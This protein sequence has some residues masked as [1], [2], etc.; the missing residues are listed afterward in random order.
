MN[1]EWFMI[2]L[3]AVGVILFP[4]GGTTWRIFLRLSLM[5]VLMGVI[6][7]FAGV[8]WW[9]DLLFAGSLAGAV[10]LPYGEKYNYWIKLATFTAYSLATFWIGWTW[11]QLISPPVCLLIFFLS[12]WKPTAGIFLWKICEACFGLLIAVMVASII[13]R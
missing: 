9:R 4:A 10:S 7:F 8:V 12:N 13:G 3:F 1:K 2:M 5:P 11:W 6:C